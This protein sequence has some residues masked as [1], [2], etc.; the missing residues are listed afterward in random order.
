M[1]LEVSDAKAGLKAWLAVD[2]II[3]HHYCGGLRMLPDVS[4]SEL[5]EL[6]KAMTQ[7]HAF[8]GLPHGGAKAGIVYDEGSQSAGKA[9]FLTA[10]A[11]NIQDLLRQR[12]YLPGA[13]MGTTRDD[14][15]E[16]MKSV[17]I[18]VPERALRGAPSGW[19]TSLTVIASAKTAAAHRAW[20]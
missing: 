14:I 17:G 12:V 13:D 3:D 11:Q 10:F 6:A 19:Y 15:R 7:K 9:K 1:V 4:A 20:A 8:L 2:S 5:S 18:R 16:M